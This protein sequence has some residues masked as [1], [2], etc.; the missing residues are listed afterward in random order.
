MIF[1]LFLTL[2]IL[3][4]YVEIINKSELYSMVNACDKRIHIYCDKVENQTDKLAEA[5]GYSDAE[6]SQQLVVE[7]EKNM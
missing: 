3:E 5:I 2:D 6:F 1:A 7:N 4:K